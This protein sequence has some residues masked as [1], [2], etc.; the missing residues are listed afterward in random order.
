MAQ[1]ERRRGSMPRRRY[2]PEQIVRKQREAEVELA[3]GQ[4]TGD[5]L[6]L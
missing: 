4:T 1:I 2:T 6:R 3:T 5:V